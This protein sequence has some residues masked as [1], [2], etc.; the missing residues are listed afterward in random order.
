VIESALDLERNLAV[1]RRG[2]GAAA[3]RA[4][5]DPGGVTVVAVAKG[6]PAELVRWAAG[7]GIADVGENYVQEMAAKRQELEPDAAPLRWHFVGT[8]QRS[9]AHR[10]A[11]L[12]DVVHTLGSA[13][14]AARLAGRAERDGRRIPALIE[15]DFTGHR[16]GVSA[17]DLPA[18]AAE[19]RALR[20]MELRGLMTLPPLTE[21]P[22]RAR[23][24]FRR[25]RELRD[26][27]AEGPGDLPELS[28][29]MSGDYEVAVEEGATMIRIGT[30]LFGDRPTT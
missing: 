24:Y 4:G 29:G 20:G 11:D 13:H 2:V 14:A 5:R 21:D 1:I 26:G 10:V 9:T 19:V 3:A 8:L 15:V 28:M 25:L 30:A 17:R 7:A 22:E 12:A 27:I 16:V 18:F 6:L 23:P